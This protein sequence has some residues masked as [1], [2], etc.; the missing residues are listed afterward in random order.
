MINLFNNFLPGSVQPFLEPML[1]WLIF[2][3]G[4]C[5]L[6]FGGKLLVKGAVTIA[7]KMGVPIILIGLTIVAFG[8]SAPELFLNIIAAA[9]GNLYLCFGNV[10]GSNIA[11]I[12]LV[13]GLSA[14]AGPLV[15]HS[16]V[17]KRELPW[18]LGVTTLMLVFAW[19]G[20]RII[21]QTEILRCISRWEAATFLGLFGLLSWH[22][23]R[24]SRSDVDDP[25]V[26]EAKDTAEEETYKTI[27]KAWIMTVLGLIALSLGGYLGKEG[28]V[29]I[30][31]QFDIGEEVIGLTIV[32]IATSLPEI[33]TSWH[34]CR[35]GLFDLAVGNVIGSNLFN[36]LLVFGVT[37]L[38]HP[39]PI[40]EPWGW[41]D[42]G[43]LFFV[44]II[45]FIIAS[46]N[47]RVTRW[48]GGMLMFGY[49]VYMGFC[50]L[51][52][53]RPELFAEWFESVGT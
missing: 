28:A 38:V 3:I 15:V 23:F 35:K 47:K 44:T 45:T 12:G 20:S 14:M 51:R 53:S 7:S 48:E 18:L 33:S 19:V 29:E 39:I 10:I 37:G 50:V 1:P 24:Q 41:F 26:Q 16:G 43:A 46:T 9:D 5:M 27:S 2:L 22:W 4:I 49:F 30:A 52:E 40:P 32:A 6:L 21:F 25:L 31:K 8:T 13:L 42:L 36:I 34:A 17:L 11:N